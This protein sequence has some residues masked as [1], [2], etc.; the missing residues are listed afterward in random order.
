MSKKRRRHIGKVWMVPFV[1][2]GVSTSLELTYDYNG[3]S[4]S[5][6]M[7]KLP[8]VLLSLESSMVMV[9]V[10]VMMMIRGCH[11]CLLE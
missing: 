9:M 10:M 2:W 8:L 3:L 4:I 1:H 7:S 6:R 5:T 11:Y